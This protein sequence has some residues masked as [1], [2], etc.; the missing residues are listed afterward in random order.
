MDSKKLKELL[1]SGE[2]IC[3]TVKGKS[4][5]PFVRD[6]VDAVFAKKTNRPLKKG[7]VAFFEDALGRIVMHRVCKITPSGYIFRGDSMRQTEGP[8]PQEK[9]LAVVDKIK[10]GDKIYTKKSFYCFIFR[11]FIKIIRLKH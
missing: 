9:V 1:T 5:Q 4:M 11:H 3:L 10:R 6:N 7:D 8:V 2:E